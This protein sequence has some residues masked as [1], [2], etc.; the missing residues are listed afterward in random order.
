MIPN[1]FIG[2]LTS[3]TILMV[4]HVAMWRIFKVRKQIL[5]LFLIFFGLPSLSFLFAVTSVSDYSSEKWTLGYLLV[6]SISGAYV[7]IYPAAQAASPSMVILLL[8]NAHKQKGGMTKA[9]I[10]DVMK[11]DT[12]FEDRIRDLHNDGLFRDDD[13]RPGL[14]KPGRFVAMIFF[15]YRR[16]LRLPR[17]KG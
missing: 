7:F 8:L 16:L 5:W 14:S 6:M 9:E 15:Y 17:G 13:I 1:I 2:A 11:S 10:L 12:L 3:F 4:I